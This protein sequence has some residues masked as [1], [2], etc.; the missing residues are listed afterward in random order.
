MDETRANEPTPMQNRTTVERKSDRELVVTRSF[1]APARIVFEA[2]TKP[3]LFKQWWTP[4]S[5]GMFLRS[6]EMDVRVGGGY[7]LVFGHDDSHPAEFFGR[8]LEVTPPSRLVWTNDEGGD[9]GP[10]TT[11]TFEEKG[12]KTLLVMHEVYPSKEALDAAGTGAADAMGE[13]FGQL[14]ELLPTLRQGAA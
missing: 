7:R 11:V 1:D 12:G 8:Y 14:D 3:E 10:V 5:M 4:K 13:T 2:W 9:G 6:C